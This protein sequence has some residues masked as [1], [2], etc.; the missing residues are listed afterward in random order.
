M[1]LVTINAKQAKVHKRKQKAEGNE[2]NSISALAAQAVF[3]I[4]PGLIIKWAQCHCYSDLMSRPLFNGTCKFRS[5]NNSSH[6]MKLLSSPILI[7]RYFRLNCSRNWVFSFCVRYVQM[8]VIDSFRWDL[9]LISGALCI[10]TCMLRSLK[11]IKWWVT[12]LP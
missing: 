4:K 9:L 8:V 1:H 2:P 3:H 7:T 5:P 11:K 12:W 6:K 10:I